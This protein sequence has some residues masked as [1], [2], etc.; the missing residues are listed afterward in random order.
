MRKK[1]AEGTFKRYLQKSV[2]R[3]IAVL[4]AAGILMFI[5]GFFIITGAINESNA[6]KNAG[7]LEAIYRSLY[8]RNQQFLTAEETT[9]ICR[10]MLAG[11]AVAEQM[12]MWFYRFN[13]GNDVENQII[14]SDESGDIL[15]SSFPEKQLSNYLINY[16][17]AICFNAGNRPE[18]DF[19]NAVYYD[20]GHYADYMFVRTITDGNEILGYVTLFLSGEDWNFYLSDKN[21]DGVITDMRNNVIYLSRANFADSANKFYGTGKRLSYYNGDRYWVKVRD[22]E[23]YQVRI[24]SLVYHPHNSTVLIGIAVIAA[25][26]ICWYNIADKMAASMA[27]NNARRIEKLVSEIRIIQKGAHDYRVDMGIEDEFAVVAHQLNRMLDSIQ[28]LNRQNTELLTFNNALEVSRLTAQ[29]NP[30]FL[31]NTLEIIRNMVVQDKKKAD[32]LILELTQL[33]R[34]SISYGSKDVRLEEDMLHI[35]AYLN[36]QKCRFGNRFQYDIQIDEDCRSCTVPKL[37]LQPIIENSIKYGF[38]K[39][40]E[41]R[42]QITGKRKGTALYL[43]VSDDGPGMET[44]AIEALQASFEGIYRQSGSF[45]LYNI[46]RRLY[47]QYGED[48]KLTIRNKVG[49]GFEVTVRIAQKHQEGL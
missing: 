23:E 16:N 10:Q 45:G 15:Y 20:A 18:Q 41:V 3:S 11:E 42:V 1:K 31:Y 14:I 13:S 36:I 38:Q 5:V 28:E 33:L 27:E 37:V 7:M 46:A 34:Y 21:F 49:G 17:G 24:Y 26:S 30:H 29:I 22:L 12:E 48:S 40:M 8:E 47:L 39:K 25:M 4:L 44:C 43:I 32:E 9:R 35:Q 6:E 2:I 19:Y